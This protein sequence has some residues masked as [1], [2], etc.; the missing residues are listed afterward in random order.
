MSLTILLSFIGASVLLAL[1]PGP[2][3]LL[4]MTESISNGKKYGLSLAAG[5]CSG[6]LIHTFAAASGISLILLNSPSAFFIL[7]IFGALYLIHL[8]FSS[9][10]DRPPKNLGGVDIKEFNFWKMAKKGFIMNVLNPKVSL[11][12]IAFLPQFLTKDGIHI[13]IQMC[14]LGIL[15]MLSAFSVFSCVAIVAARL[16][17]LVM[18]NN[19]WVA[20]NYVKCIILM[21]LALGLLLAEP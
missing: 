11:F 7:K 4:V 19:F 18:K 5:L 3:I 12:F 9:L 13:S 17:T 20:S 15:F 1:M 8:A 2:D 16:N 10:K 14:I 6:V 21:L